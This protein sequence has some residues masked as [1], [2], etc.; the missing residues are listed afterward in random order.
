MKPFRVSAEWIAFAH[1]PGA[2]DRQ[3]T[4]VYLCSLITWCAYVLVPPHRVDLVEEIVSVAELYDDPHER[5]RCAA[6]RRLSKRAHAWLQS[7]RRERTHAYFVQQG[8][9]TKRQST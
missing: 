6:A 7:A 4:A 1:G 2:D 9:L 8:L 5:R 3:P